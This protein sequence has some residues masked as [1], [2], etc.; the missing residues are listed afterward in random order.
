MKRPFRTSDGSPLFWPLFGTTAIVSA[1]MAAIDGFGELPGGI[2]A[3]EFAAASESSTAAF[4]ADYRG[5]LRKSIFVALSIGLDYLFMA[6][7]STWLAYSCAQI[8]NQNFCPRLGSILVWFSWLAAFF[9]AIENF[10]LLMLLLERPYSEWGKLTF[11]CVC[12]KFAILVTG[13][14][15]CV[16]GVIALSGKKKSA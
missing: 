9:D 2:V 6:V 12:A 16:A 11:F 7:Y 1:A 10:G 13:L 5:S 8:A 14:L 15:Y 3:F 4:V